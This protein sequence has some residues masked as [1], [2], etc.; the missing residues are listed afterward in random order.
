[1]TGPYEVK[2]VMI[3]SYAVY[4][5]NPYAGAMRGFGATQVAV[6]YEQQMDIIARELKISPVEIRLKNIL[7]VGSYTATGQLLNNSIPLEQCL[8]SIS[9]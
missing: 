6:A 5:N 7:R 9:E 2:N 1:A 8:K 4:T 3:D